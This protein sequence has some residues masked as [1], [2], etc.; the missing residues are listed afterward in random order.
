VGR[1]CDFHAAASASAE[2]PL[3]NETAI[4]AGVRPFRAI[5][6][7]FP[8]QG[9]RFTGLRQDDGKPDGSLC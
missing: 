2:A 9:T 4:F 8:L 6:K 3:S 1:L 5:D 7:L